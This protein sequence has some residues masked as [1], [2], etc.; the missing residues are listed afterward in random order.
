MAVGRSAQAIPDLAANMN[1]VQG[2]L[3]TT[4]L[5]YLR[6]SPSSR[7]GVPWASRQWEGHPLAGSHQASGT[8]TA[9]GA[10]NNAQIS[11]H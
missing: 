1:G 4:L 2:S 6:T 8:C 9:Q 5:S 3:A 10:Q 11:H 7:Q